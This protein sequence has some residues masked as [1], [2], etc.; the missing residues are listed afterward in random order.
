MRGDDGDETRLTVGPVII[1][2]NEFVDGFVAPDYIVDDIIQ[3]GRLLSLTAKTGHGKTAIAT[4]LMFSFAHG[5]PFG[6]RPVEQ[7]KVLFL[8]GENPD[9]VRARFLVCSDVYDLSINENIH[10]VPG[11]FDIEQQQVFI[12]RQVNSIG[13]LTAVIIDTSAAYFMGTEEND[14][15]QMIH[16]AHVLRKL[17]E[18]PGKPAII[19][20]CHPVK[21]ASKDNLLP[22]GGGAFL[23]EI[24][25]NLTLWSDDNGKTTQLHWQGK[26]RGPGFEPIDFQLKTETSERVKD[27]KG[28][29]IPSVA[30]H[31]MSE[32]KKTELTNA[33]RSDED[34]LL[35]IMKLW[36]N[37]SLAD[38]CGQLGWVGKTDRPQKSRAHRTLACLKDDSL[39]T[40]YR[41]H[42]KLTKAGKKEVDKRA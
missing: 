25:G 18:L 26:L 32:E 8:A 22:R 13:D 5:V 14:N 34:N 9:D 30:A 4:S 29:L 1:T 27:V 7:G 40:K 17:S 12:K 20:P 2:G 28:R 10:V 19:V 24:D 36:P 35:D 41:G 39:V 15:V 38:W 31:P 11:I 21:N 6:G 33:A 23:N 37:G 3:R 16:H 42:Y